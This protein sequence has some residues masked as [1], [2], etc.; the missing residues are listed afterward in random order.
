MVL[1][2]YKEDIKKSDILGKTK[3]EI[4]MSAK[5]AKKTYDTDYPKY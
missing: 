3:D 4:D 5:K 1:N 2:R